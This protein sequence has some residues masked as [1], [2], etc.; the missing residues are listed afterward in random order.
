[1]KKI[2]FILILLFSTIINSQSLIG[3]KYIAY[4]GNKCG[5][6]FSSFFFTELNFQ[7]DIVFISDYFTNDIGDTNAKE[8]TESKKYNYKIE[9]NYLTIIGSKYDRIEITNNQLKSNNLIFKIVTENQTL[10]IFYS[11]VNG[12]KDGLYSKLEITIDSTKYQN[13]GNIRFKRESSEKTNKQLW[14]KLIEKLDVNEFK[15]LDQI[16][17]KIYSYGLN[18]EIII[19]I[20]NMKYKILNPNQNI[21]NKMTLE[22][23]QML[24]VESEKSIEKKL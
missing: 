15:K 21:I 16:I 10:K 9:N 19:E 22:F 24:R 4:L 20:D 1:M 14:Q 7:N 11:E 5:G 18:E 6:E 13:G 2:I 3:K 17:P 23:I 12:G 8:F